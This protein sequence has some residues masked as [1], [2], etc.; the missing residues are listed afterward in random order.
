MHTKVSLNAA[1]VIG[2]ILPCIFHQVTGSGVESLPKMPAL[3]DSD[4][5]VA[6]RGYEGGGSLVSC[7][8]R[9][10]GACHALLSRADAPPPPP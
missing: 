1:V 8:R 2:T 7:R 5:A 6:P 9:A 3:A 10:G 4:V